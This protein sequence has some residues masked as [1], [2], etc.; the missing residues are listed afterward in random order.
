LSCICT[1]ATFRIVA[2]TPDLKPASGSMTVYLEVCNIYLLL[3]FITVFLLIKNNIFEPMQIVSYRLYGTIYI[4][5]KNVKKLI[6][7]RD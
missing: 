3:L 7:A 4:A 5:P 6:G 2:V 1:S